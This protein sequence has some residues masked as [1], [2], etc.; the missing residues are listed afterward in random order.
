MYATHPTYPFILYLII[1]IM[2]VEGQA[3]N[4]DAPHYAV[5]PTH[6]FLSYSNVQ[7]YSSAL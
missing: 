3:T 5:L 2:L 7:I 4:I 1:Q 6:L